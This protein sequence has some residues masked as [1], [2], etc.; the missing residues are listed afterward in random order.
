MKILH[1]IG[2]AVALIPFLANAALATEELTAED[3]SIK[4]EVK[5]NANN[6]AFGFDALWVAAGFNV[7]RID[8]TSN[9]VT[10]IK[11]EDASQKQRRVA[12]GEGAVWI[13]DVGSNAIY[14]IDPETNSV[15]TKISVNMLST[16]GSIG[17]GEASVWV[18]TAERFEKTLARYDAEN[19]ELIATIELPSS[20]VGVT[21]GYGSVWVTSNMGDELLRI[22]PSTNTVVGTTK[23][24][25]GPLFMVTG[26]GSV[27]VHIQSDASIQRVNAETGAVLATIKTG[28][29]RGTGDI[30]AGGGYVW[31]NTPYQVPVAQVDPETNTLVRKF[32]GKLGGDSIRFGADSLWIGGPSIRRVIP[33]N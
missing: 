6:M 33:P 16:Q 31:I 15:A 27:W 20:G 18:V 32:T 24:E 13:P 1:R 3:L 7:L 17:V 21:V 19:G 12:V 11:L 9:T 5:R 2:Y 8:A 30:D 10:E 28:L 23:L 29:P 25:D 14:K 22:D 4:L 26:H